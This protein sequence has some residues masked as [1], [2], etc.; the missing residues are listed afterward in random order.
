MICSSL[1]DGQFGLV[2]VLA[3]LPSRTMPDCSQSFF[4]WRLDFA[5]A[6]ARGHLLGERSS[7]STVRR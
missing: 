3:G 7:R 6:E 5:D 4:R 1:G 2:P